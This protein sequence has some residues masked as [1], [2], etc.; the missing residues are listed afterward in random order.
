M[1]DRP[2]N[3]VVSTNNSL[4]TLAKRGGRRWKVGEIVFD[5]M[6]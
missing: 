1:V 6:Y 4:N 5:I 3:K 2:V